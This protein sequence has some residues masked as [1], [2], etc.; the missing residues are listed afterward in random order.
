MQSL[1][2]NPTIVLSFRLME[3]VLIGILKGAVARFRG[4]GWPRLAFLFFHK[5]WALTLYS[6]AHC[7]MM[8]STESVKVPKSIHIVYVA[9]CNAEAK[10]GLEG[11]SQCS[12]MWLTF[13]NIDHIGYINLVHF[14]KNSSIYEIWCLFTHCPYSI[15]ITESSSKCVTLVKKNICVKITLIFQLGRQHL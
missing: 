11:A 10:H 1:P 6:C 9:L 5:S 15:N 4:K 14:F 13:A 2:I 12:H 3:L 8:F 7:T